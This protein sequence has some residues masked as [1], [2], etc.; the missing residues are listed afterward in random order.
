MLWGKKPKK[1]PLCGG[2]S[3]TDAECQ[4]CVS[5]VEACYLANHQN[6]PLVA[7]TYDM[8]KMRGLSGN[9]AR[10]EVARQLLEG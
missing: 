10:R 5:L 9:A 6:W 3:E 2:T 7:F 8:V 4:S 1:C